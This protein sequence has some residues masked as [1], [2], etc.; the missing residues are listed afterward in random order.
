MCELLIH[1]LINSIKVKDK[2]RKLTTK[3]SNCNYQNLFMKDPN[4]D[5]IIMLQ[6]KVYPVHRRILG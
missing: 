6:D 3:L 1:V 5:L 2:M 4:S